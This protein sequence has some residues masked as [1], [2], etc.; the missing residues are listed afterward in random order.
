M[1]KECT[2]IGNSFMLSFFEYDDE[3]CFDKDLIFPCN[4]NNSPLEDNIEPKEFEF[5]VFPNI[6][7]CDCN[8][9]V[10]N[11]LH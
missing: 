3:S 10:L 7:E 8:T 5:S 6:K 1:E 4:G 11:P 2:D 9:P